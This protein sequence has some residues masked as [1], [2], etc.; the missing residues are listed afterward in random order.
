M[1]LSTLKPGERVLDIK[2]PKTGENIDLKIELYSMKSEKVTRFKTKIQQ[3][4]FNNA[5][6]GKET[7]GEEFT[8]RM[9]KMA[10]ECMKSWTWGKDLD[11]KGKKPH[12]NEKNVR[13]VFEALPWLREQVEKALQDEKAFFTG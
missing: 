3:D 9:F 6:E 11:F 12:F 13:E 2:H 8:E 4:E 10:F 5:K 1:D 7:S